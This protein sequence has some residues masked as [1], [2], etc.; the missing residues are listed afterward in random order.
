MEL[1]YAEWLPD[2]PDY[3]NP[4][5][6][7]AKNVVPGSN[8][9]EKFPSAVVYSN[10]LDARCRG[11][12]SF[13]DAS[14]NTNNFSGNASKLYKSSGGVYADVSKVGGYTTGTD[15]RWEFAKYG[16]RIIAT[17][18]SDPIQSYVLGSSS[19][20]ANLSA[21]APQA[22]HI[23]IM[24]SF[25][26]LG[27]T[28]DSSDG[29]VPYRLRWSALDNPTDYTISASTQ[30]D[31]QDLNATRGW[32]QAVCGGDYGVIFQERAISR[33]VYE[34]SPT[35]FRFDEVQPGK[36]TPAPSSVIQ[37]GSLIPYLGIDGFEMFDGSQV[38]PI[39]ANKVD[40]TFWNEVDLSYLNR[41]FAVP[42]FDKKLVYWA[43]PAT[44]NSNG[45]PNKILCF[46][47]TTGHWSFIEQEVEFLYTSLSEGYT[48]DSLDST[49]YNLD[50]LPFSLDSRVWTG[51][52]YILSGFNTDHK[53]INF[54]GTA[55]D[56]TVETAE[57]QLFP[58]YRANI[59]NTRPLVDGSATVTVQIGARDLLS[60][61][62]SYG[63]AASVN[64]SGFAPVRSNARYHRVR[65]NTIGDF[66]DAQGVEIVDAS[67]EGIR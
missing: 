42:D 8:N 17:N 31:F 20:F 57:I 38:I 40:R 33:M 10:A 5:A 21:S 30:A 14:G 6:T 18:F 54:S 19:A 51:E 48:L 39:G 9:Y 36:G 28:F 59:K 56:A 52:N 63:A 22:R 15:E 27:N 3:K 45:N 62:V 49:G 2:L 12:V 29:N 25:V 64:A 58:N 50:T 61:S 11:A 53:Q 1:L 46:N 43:Y 66:N 7:I 13:K 67:R 26:V 4:G 60:D 23:A 32:V 16:E 37:I 55:K 24:R 41:I 35:I 34:G 65:V 47:L 44:G